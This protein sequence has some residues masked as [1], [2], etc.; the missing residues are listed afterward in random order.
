MRE[1]ATTVNGTGCGS[2]LGPYRDRCD[3]KGGDTHAAGQQ[4]FYHYCGTCRRCHVANNIGFR[5]PER[6]AGQDG[7]RIFQGLL[8]TRPRDGKVSVQRFHHQRGGRRGGR[9]PEPRGRRRKGRRF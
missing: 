3:G 9:L 1:E 8:R 5:R 6:D 7:G 4:V 2:P